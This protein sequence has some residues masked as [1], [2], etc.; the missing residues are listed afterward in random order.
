M[1]PLEAVKTNWNHHDYIDI[2]VVIED[3]INEMLIR[4]VNENLENADISTDRLKLEELK[5]GSGDESGNCTEM[6]QFLTFRCYCYC[7]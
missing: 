4:I 2:D 5:F 1:K 7:N 3:D 6:I